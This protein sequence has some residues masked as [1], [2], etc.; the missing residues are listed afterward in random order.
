MIGGVADLAAL[1]SGDGETGVGDLLD[2]RSLRPAWMDQGACRTAPAEVTW[3]P[4]QGGDFRTPAAICRACPVLRA[5][6]DWSLAQGPELEG[7]WGGLGANGRAQLR[8]H[9]R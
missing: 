6:R 2:W 1:Y 7:V 4:G 5:C 9:F 8:R 3:F